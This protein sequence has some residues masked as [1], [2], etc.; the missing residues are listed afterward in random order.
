MQDVVLGFWKEVVPTF[1][2]WVTLTVFSIFW[3][4]HKILTGFAEGVYKSWPSSSNPQVIFKTLLTWS[5]V[6]NVHLFTL[7]KS[8]HA[9]YRMHRD[10]EKMRG[11][12]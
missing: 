3:E 5:L 6:W 1:T 2:N 7:I 11:P 8:Q 10:R 4:K 12:V 9:E